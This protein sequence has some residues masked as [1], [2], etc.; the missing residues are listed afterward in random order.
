MFDNEDDDDY[1]KEGSDRD[2]FDDFNQI[3]KSSGVAIW[4]KMSSALGC[5]IIMLLIVSHLRVLKKRATQGDFE[6][7]NQLLLPIYWWLI[8]GFAF[9]FFIEG[10]YTWLWSVEGDGVDCHSRWPLGCTIQSL[11]AGIELGCRRGIID[12]VA[13]FLMH[14]GAG[15]GSVRETVYVLIPWCAFTTFTEFLWRMRPVNGEEDYGTHRQSDW[16]QATFWTAH[17]T[18][19]NFKTF[20]LICELIFIG[21]L[22]LFYGC[23]AICPVTMV[24]RRPSLG[25]VYIWWQL[26]TMLL[27]LAEVIGVVSVGFTD[28]YCIHWFTFTALQV[29]A[30]PIILLG[31]LRNDSKYWQGLLFIDDDPNTSSSHASHMQ[32][33]EYSQSIAR[34]S[35]P[36]E[37][38]SR[39]S[40][41]SSYSALT[42][43]SRTMFTP[44]RM[45]SQGFLADMLNSFRHR[46]SSPS[47]VH[48]AHLTSSEQMPPPS[49][50]VTLTQPLL[51]QTLLTEA[52]QE[53]AH[54]MEMLSRAP[55][56]SFIHFGL[57]SIE[58]TLEFDHPS[59]YVLGAGG[60]AKVYRGRL[61][62]E[63]VAIKMI[64][65][66]DITADIV[67]AFRE[68]VM[69]LAK[70][71]QHPSI[72]QVKGFSVMPP[73]LCV[74]MELCSKGSLLDILKD[75][76]ETAAKMGEHNRMI[77]EERQDST[78][79]D[80]SGDNIEEGLSLRSSIGSNES[81][82]AILARSWEERLQMAC[83]CAE[84]LA[85]MH[86][87]VPPVMHKDIKSAN[88]LVVENLDVGHY[89]RR[90]LPEGRQE[91]TRHYE[92]R[93]G[94]L[95]SAV[96]SLVELSA[97]HS[98]IRGSSF[99]MNQRPIVQRSNSG[100]SLIA[101]PRRRNSS[102]RIDLRGSIAEDETSDKAPS[103]SAKS[104]G[105][106]RN[107]SDHSSSLAD[108][109]E[110]FIY[111]LNDGVTPNWAAPEVLEAI[112]SIIPKKQASHLAQLNSPTGDN[113]T[114]ML[115]DHTQRPSV[116]N[117]SSLTSEP[118]LFSDPYTP[119]SDVYS[120][121]VVLWEIATC[122]TPFEDA[123]FMDLVHRIGR[124]HETP[125]IP[126]G[127]PKR[128]KS[129]LK[130][131]WKPDP[132]KRPSAM[133]VVEI[134]RTIQREV[135]TGDVCPE[136]PRKTPTEPGSSQAEETKHEPQPSKEST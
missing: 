32:S 18:S 10:S 87:Q 101:G 127:L 65:S 76:N 64:W 81:E 70:L 74:V 34:S 11:V 93:L 49:P 15:S 40:Q 73:A 38:R 1:D 95:G 69:M 117:T 59:A 131:C 113:N 19:H 29:I 2:K 41:G 16:M 23:L 109:D 57:L 60:A 88:Y 128:Y 50:S 51:G 31:T 122:R 90:S 48:G 61:C 126:E 66:V 42:T 67:S 55:H 135:E 13:V 83:E 85:F 110:S 4:L 80:H 27:I 129:L 37:I 30:G 134:L 6:A 54:T 71:A 7:A 22:I 62:G 86:M 8:V 89:S 24:Y 77:V 104:S 98:S 125:K 108:Y 3:C 26:L 28:G 68:E 12:G 119:A 116:D 102:S 44:S 130:A 111:R 79:R 53:L 94:D 14:H 39:P 106:G 100:Q 46:P 17:N 105:S 132:S 36:V 78:Q 47:S 133:K 25:R 56:C 121:G 43:N 52:A 124:K 99:D 72:V 112:L 114:T 58:T 63:P 82:V 75:F 35:H 136:T 9:T 107:G 21:L 118:P 115:P 84:G 96:E 97:D 45:P 91:R 103:F 120:L 123:S 20:S 92:V 5:F 33:R